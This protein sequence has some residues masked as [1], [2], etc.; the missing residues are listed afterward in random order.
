[1][2]ESGCFSATAK[3]LIQQRGKDMKKMILAVVSLLILCVGTV[4]AADLVVYAALDQ[5][6][7]R[8]IIKAFKE[9]TGLDAELALQIE[10]AGTVAARIKTEA[11]V[12]GQMFSSEK[13]EHSCWPRMRDF[14]SPIVSP[15][16]KMPGL[17]QI[18]GYSGILDGL[19]PRGDVHPLQH[20]AV[21]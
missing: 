3:D 10:Q 2:L 12:R 6:T 13:L 16:L 5:E 4:Q 7:P 17:I 20:E 14:S 21:Q 15:W 8:Q 1:V 9:A 11:K 19:V 18:H